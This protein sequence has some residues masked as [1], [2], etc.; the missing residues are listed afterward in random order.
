MMMMT[1]T[2]EQQE[3]KDSRPGRY[4]ALRISVEE[5]RPQENILDKTR[6]DISDEKIDWRID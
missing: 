3:D 2:N 1:N 6:F 4:E 5:P